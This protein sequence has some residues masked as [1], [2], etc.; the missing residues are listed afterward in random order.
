MRECCRRY[1]TAITGLALFI[2]I[3]LTGA[4]KTRGQKKLSIAEKLAAGREFRE[5]LEIANANRS[6]SGQTQTISTSPEVRKFETK[7]PIYSDAAKLLFSKKELAEINEQAKQLNEQLAPFAN[8]NEE[9]ELSRAG[10][11]RIIM[12]NED[13]ENAGMLFKDF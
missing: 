13:A 11:G 12:T 5:P 6:F 8:W 9:Q 4:G 10:L 3:V 1:G 7:N 2:M